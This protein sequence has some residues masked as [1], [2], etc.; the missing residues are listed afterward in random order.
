MFQGIVPHVT[1]SHHFEVIPIRPQDVIKYCPQQSSLSHMRPFIQVKKLQALLE[2]VEDAQHPKLHHH[3][4]YMLTA[5]VLSLN[6]VGI[7]L[8]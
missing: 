6:Y 4:S 8:T 2:V 3:I 7:D 1:Y 5:R